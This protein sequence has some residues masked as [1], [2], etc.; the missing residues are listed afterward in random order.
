MKKTLLRI[1]GGLC[2]LLGAIGIFLPMLPTTP[3]VLLAALCFS[4]SHEKA[5]QWLLKNR[6]FG[7]YIENYRTG[8]GVP[9]R[10]KIR[11]ICWL[12][13]TLIPCIILI[14]SIPLRFM[15]AVMGSAVTVHL[16][17]LKTRGE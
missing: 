8:R 12:W 7:P 13:I 16:V 15:L 11:A 17:M 6:T 10:T 3:F 2:L 4:Y 1:A 9:L 14:Q 5:Y